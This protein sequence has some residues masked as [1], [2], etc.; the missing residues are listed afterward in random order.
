[1]KTV[2]ILLVPNYVTPCTTIVLKYG[3]YKSDTQFYFFFTETY[4]F[5]LGQTLA[6]LG[7][8]L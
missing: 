7:E 6:I 4:L 8:W 3:P 2:W 1:M 5:L